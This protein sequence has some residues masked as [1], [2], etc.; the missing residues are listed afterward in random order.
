[1]TAGIGYQGAGQVH[2]GILL[3][4]F[5]MLVG[6]A[7]YAAGRGS[8][9]AVAKASCG[10]HDRPESGL[11]G[12]TTLAERFSSDQGNA[13]TCNLELMSQ[14]RGAGPTMDWFFSTL[15]LTTQHF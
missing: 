11:Q 5:F 9:Q 8:D 10:P 1:M 2:A 14:F 6:L 4:S 7:T 13:Y 12:Q 3:L 15:A